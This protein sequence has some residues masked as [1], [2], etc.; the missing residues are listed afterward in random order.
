MG[1]SSGAGGSGGSRGYSLPILDR[2]AVLLEEI[3]VACEPPGV[4]ALARRT[5]IPKTSVDRMVETLKAYGMVTAEGPGLV[6]GPRMLQL[7]ETIRY[8]TAENLGHLLLPL[9]IELY[10]KTGD[11]VLLAVLDGPHAVVVQML[12]G[13]GRRHLAAHGRVPAHRCAAGKALLAPSAGTP[14]WP[15]T[16]SELRRST[17]R[18]HFDTAAFTAELHRIRRQ[19]FATHRVQDGTAELAMPVVGHTGPVA[20]LARIRRVDRPFDRTT[21]DLQRQIAVAASASLRP[22]AP[23][24]GVRAAE[25]PVAP[26][27]HALNGEAHDPG[28][29]PGGTGR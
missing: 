23:T 13:P 27:G 12:A 19:G 21:I 22:A 2:A 9:L 14:R 4:S 26:A 28:Y 17:P 15:E 1:I 11:V 8:R 5:G 20:A 18:G 3:A 16:L 6:I 10:E 29:A 25:R 7:A 24:T